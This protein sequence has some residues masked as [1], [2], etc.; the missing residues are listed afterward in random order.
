MRQLAYPDSGL[1]VSK[2]KIISLLQRQN[3]MRKP[4]YNV[5]YYT[6]VRNFLDCT[7]RFKKADK[8]IFSETRGV[9]LYSDH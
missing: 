9:H 6:N 8:A 1:L 5:I 3:H 4:F 2:R 7:I